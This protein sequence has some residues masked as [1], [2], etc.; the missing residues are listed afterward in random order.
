MVFDTW[1]GVLDAGEYREFSLRYME[2]IVAELTRERDGRRVPLILFTKGGGAWLDAMAADGL[3]RARR[4]LDDGSRGRAARGAATAS[5]CRATSTRT[6]LYAPPEAIRAEVARVLAS[7]GHGHGHVFNL[8]HGIHPRVDPEHAGAMVAAVHELARTITELVRGDGH[9][10]LRSGSRKGDRHV[11]R[12]AFAVS[13]SRSA[14][15]RILP[16]LVFGSSSRKS[17]CF[18]TL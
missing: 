2:R 5:R 8:G 7:Y 12:T 17:T 6:A 4:R 11:L 16:T 3:R 14:R 10:R 18:G 1:G 15:R 9:R 13:S